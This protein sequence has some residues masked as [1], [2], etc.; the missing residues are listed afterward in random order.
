MDLPQV[1]LSN[2][3]ELLMLFVGGKRFCESIINLPYPSKTFQTE[4]NFQPSNTRLCHWA[5]VDVT[6]TPPWR[7]Q[8][9]ELGCSV[10]AEQRK[11]GT[12][13][14]DKSG[15]VNDPSLYSLLT[16]LGLQKHG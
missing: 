13:Y 16:R 10:P 9:Y 7:E 4:P 5:S 1:P 8:L 3:R 15:E 11:Y 14:A 6:K 2:K 12:S